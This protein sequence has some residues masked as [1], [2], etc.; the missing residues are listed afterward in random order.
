MTLGSEVSMRA[1]WPRLAVLALCF[2]AAPLAVTACGE[3]AEMGEDTAMTDEDAETT[4]QTDAAAMGE[5][6]PLEGEHD[7]GEGR[8]VIVQDGA[9]TVYEGD[10]AVV[11][12]SY[13]YAADTV[14]FV[15]SGGPM[16]CGPD[17][18]G[19]YLL[20][21]DAEG[22]PSLELIED[23]C[24]GRRQDITGEDGEAAGEND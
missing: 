8:R 6:D 19:V 3:Q 4:A 10:S 9:Y 17:A 21:T 18:R 23:P 22:E 20:A 13:T 24:E 7:L 14:T 15:D 1:R 2:L 5:Q 12:G 16:S 11:E